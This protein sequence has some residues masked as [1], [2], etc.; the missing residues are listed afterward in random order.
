VSGDFRT[1]VELSP[2]RET[3]VSGN[4][5]R[6]ALP[7]RNRRT[8]G[9]WCF[10]DHLGPIESGEHEPRGIGPHPHTGLHTV[11]WLVSG[12][13]LHRDSLGS[14]ETIRPGQLN[15]MT[16]GAGISHAEE[17]VVA[18]SGALHGIQ[19]WVAQPERTRHGEGAFEH[20]D[21][22]P[23][24]AYGHGTATVL[25]GA[26][27][28][29]V[30]PARRDTDMVGIDLDLRPG[31]T[32]LPLDPAFE[33]ALVVLTGAAEVGDRRITPGHL[34]YLG[35]GRDELAL[36]TTQ[37]TRLLLLGGTPFESPIVMWWNFVGRSH[38]ELFDASTEWNAGARR[39]GETGSPLDRI[40]APVPPWRRDGGTGT[41][42]TGRF[43]GLDKG[44][45]VQGADTEAV[46]GRSAEDWPT[47]KV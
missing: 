32:S 41:A 27:G 21:E 28:S 10:A 18:R 40:P 24:A 15:L 23:Q 5:V 29:T 1:A 46:N 8:V 26:L 12:Q 47:D 38:E 25:V 19:L 2:S 7:Q 13:L 34:A 37:V 3:T 20:H 42:A 16:A 39:F 6:R 45:P 44:R 31:A 4:S 30:S 14:E 11:T 9:A 36:T 33:H 43:P 17:P 22:L 35:L